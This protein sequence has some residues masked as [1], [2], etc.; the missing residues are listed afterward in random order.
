M[1][2]QRP[3]GSTTSN[4]KR[5]MKSHHTKQRRIKNTDWP[6]NTDCI[7]C[8]MIKRNESDV[9]DIVI[10]ILA[11]KGVKFLFY[12]VFSTDRMWTHNS[13]T[14]H[15]MGFVCSISRWSGSGV[16]NSNLKENLPTCDSFPL[17]MSYMFLFVY[18]E[19]I[20]IDFDLTLIDRLDFS[21][22]LHSLRMQTLHYAVML[23][24]HSI[25]W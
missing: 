24:G 23:Q 2:A 4:L 19:G 8:D 12:V 9:A 21:Q 1:D 20:D 7:L 22:R 10:E 25:C 14:R 16:K 13:V 6:L 15:L 11:K 18:V 17:I 5:K 3:D